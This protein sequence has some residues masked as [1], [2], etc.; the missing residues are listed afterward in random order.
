M[1]TIATVLLALLL[2][3]PTVGA[4][5]GP[6]IIREIEPVAGPDWLVLDESDI[7]AAGATTLGELLADVPGIFV[8]ESGT[9]GGLVTASFRGAAA[10]QLLVMV[11]GVPINQ[12]TNG[13]A[14]LSGLPLAEFERVEIRRGVGGNRYGG[15][16]VGGVV[17]LVTKVAARADGLFSLGLG[18]AGEQRYS[19]CLGRQ[20]SPE[21]GFSVRGWLA[22]HD[23]WRDNSDS[24]EMGFRVA[25]RVSLSSHT[26]RGGYARWTKEQ[27]L[28][29]PRPA[30]GE[31]PEFGSEEATSLFDNQ[32]EDSQSA[33]L[34]YHGRLGG[35]ILHADLGWREHELSHFTRYRSFFPTEDKSRYLTTTYYGSAWGRFAIFEPV[36]LEVGL[37]YRSSRLEARLDSTVW[38]ADPFD[39]DERGTTTTTEWSPTADELGGWLEARATPGLF[40]ADARL[41]VDD[42]GVYGA[43]VT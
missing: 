36:E 41:R 30:E 3:S 18:S 8:N 32:Q 33:V 11:D 23:G 26:I 25:A 5:G 31:L 9:P 2:F 1:R 43:H 39:P 24:G 38:D 40:T 37:G 10:N 42:H 21:A 4:D 22:E 15:G 19:L 7:R 17:N 27:G 6:V 35:V 12:A 13:V 29:G 34:N 28:P 14:D 20:L 16:A